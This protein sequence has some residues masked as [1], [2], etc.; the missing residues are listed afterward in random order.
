MG[1]G[2]GGT[3]HPEVY[4]GLTLD[5]YLKDDMVQSAV[6]RCLE[7]LGEAA[8]RVSGS[9]KQSH[10]EIPWAEDHRTTERL[11]S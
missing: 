4:G 3:S 5:R 1:H 7:I 10:Q 9:F 8:R 6:E 11:G 2:R